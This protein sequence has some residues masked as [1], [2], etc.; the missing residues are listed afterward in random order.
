MAM[1]KTA[2]KGTAKATE[3]EAA[4]AKPAKAKAAPKAAAAKADVDDAAPA[5]AKAPAKKAPAKAVASK[6]A[7][8]ETKAAAGKKP[9]AL[10]IPLTPSA[11][12]A[13]IVGEDMLPRGEV[14]SKVWDYIRKHDLQKPADRR[15]IVADASLKKVFGKD[16]VTM[17]EMNKYL[18]QHLK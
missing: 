2:S 6:G 9:N 15:V 8:D 7:K 17:F 5:K 12:L 13:A 10:Q 18:A 11:E 16:E 14:V 3:G 4:P 1:S